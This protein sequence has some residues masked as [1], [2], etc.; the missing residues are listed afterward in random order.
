MNKVK[1]TFLLLFTG[2]LCFSQATYKSISSQI[3]GED[4]ELKILLPRGYS[5]DDDKAYPVIYVFDGDYLFEAVAG[6]VDYYA[7]WEDIPE[8]IVVGINQVESREDDLA[9]SEQNSLPIESGAEFFEFVGKEL[10]PFIEDNYKTETFRVAVGHGETANFINY[11]L[12]RSNPVF[13]A[14]VAISPDLALDMENYLS[15]RLKTVEQKVFYYLAV[16]NMD[17]KHI[18]ESAKIL[19]NTLKSVESNNLLYTFKEFDGPTHYA[20]PA[21]A[22]P[23][24]LESIFFV[25]QPISKK[26]YKESILK[27]EGSPVEYLEKKYQIIKDLF[28]IEKQIL[29]NDF[30]A[31]AAAIKKNQKWEYYEDLSKLA[32]A[33]Y[34]DTVLPS[35]Y[36][37][38]YLENIGESKKA[39][40]VFQS[41]YIL[42]EIGGITKDD[43]LEKAEA[44]KRDFGY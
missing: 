3:L 1:V 17:V 28:G 4:R 11:Y 2:L 24:A 20:M 42:E 36:K 12:I 27:L 18:M 21:H 38:L 6:N 9:Y 5:D 8:S 26:E 16:S 29:I 40:K 43:M 44:I 35:Y 10:I 19:D 13:N 30:K 41:G 15:E 23:K 32:K 34:P 25:F 22:I 39:M 31:I 7:Y 14:Y 37:G 33:H